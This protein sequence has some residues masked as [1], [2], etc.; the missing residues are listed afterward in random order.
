MQFRLLGPLE[1][2]SGGELVPLGGKKQRATLGALLL[3][4]NR[5]VATSELVGALWDPEEVPV[6]ARKILHNAV[7]GLRS[8][9]A[10]GPSP[11]LGE[12]SALVTQAPGYVLKVDPER[13]DLSVFRQCVSEGRA[14]LAARSPET[15]ARLLREGLDLWRGPVLADLVESGIS[16]PELD[17]VNRARLD[18]LEDLFEAE[19]ACG[20][21]H[22]VLGELTVLVEAEPLRERACG[23]LMTALYRSGRQADALNVYDRVRSAL[24]ENLGLEP[25]R[26]LQMLQ[27][28]ILT[29]DPALGA[30]TEPVP[31]AVTEPRRAAA[32]VPDRPAPVPVRPAVAPVPAVPRPTGPRAPAPAAGGGV[33]QGSTT[34]TE[35][36]P[37]SAVL[38]SVR[39]EEPAGSSP[40]EIDS[41]LGGAGDVISEVVEEFGGTMVAAIG[42]VS[43]ALFGVHEPRENHPGRAVEAALALRDRFPAG[44]GTALRAAVTTG[45][46]LVRLCP[47]AGGALLSAAGA[48]L[49]DGRTLLAQVPDGQVWMTGATRLETGDTVGFRATGGPSDTWQVLGLRTAALPSAERAHELGVLNGLLDWARYSSAPH[50][51]TVLGAPGVGKTHLL[52]EFERGLRRRAEPAGR[53]LAAREPAEDG[54]LS[55]A[56]QILSGYCGVLPGEG[57]R[58]ARDKLSAAVWRL[59]LAAARRAQLHRMLLGL[60]TGR[61]PQR[62]RPGEVLDAWVEFLTAAAAIEPVVMVFD[63][64]HLA[65]DALLD[66]LERLADGPGSAPLL[67]V[68]TARPELL[69]RRPGWSGGKARVSTLTLRTQPLER[70]TAGVARSGPPAERAVAPVAV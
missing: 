5:V 10:A 37:V 33:R 62:G 66:R 3:R 24:V 14:A 42:S 25:G 17:A 35:R 46:A 32:V 20:R 1:V 55:L 69:E 57:E 52:T 22:A 9:L 29:H 7:W 45:Q 44:H 16:W 15:A 6:T 64:V 4:A 13:V 43:L 65:D 61:G 39:H 47:D 49:D 19:L 34:V 70:A 50:L 54:A 21:Q 27:R 53:I 38:V 40:R 48:L 59:P 67:A 58:T 56:A 23:Q 26:G 60:L 11:T 36:I 30:G 2:T 28:Q 12:P 68:A 51:V 18:A 41:A 8:M 31:A 63:D